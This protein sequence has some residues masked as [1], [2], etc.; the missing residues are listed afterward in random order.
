MVAQQAKG[1]QTEAPLLTNPLLFKQGFWSKA[2]A[3]DSGKPVES[4]SCSSASKSDTRRLAA[5]RVYAISILAEVL[6]V[7][8]AITELPDLQQRSLLI[9]DE[10]LSSILA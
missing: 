2:K 1:L 4:Q 3:V 8:E 6:S 7:K 5:K 10:V 9:V